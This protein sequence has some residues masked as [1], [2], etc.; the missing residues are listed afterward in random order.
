MKIPGLHNRWFFP[1]GYKPQKRRQKYTL[2]NKLG[3]I[4]RAIWGHFFFFL[5]TQQHWWGVIKDTTVAEKGDQRLEIWECV[6]KLGIWWGDYHKF[7]YDSARMKSF[8]FSW[9]RNKI[10]INNIWGQKDDYINT[11]KKGGFAFI[12]IGKTRQQ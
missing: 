9:P 3:G 12:I 5:G 11:W 1:W 8:S 2:K 10:E 6:Q 4:F 7:Y